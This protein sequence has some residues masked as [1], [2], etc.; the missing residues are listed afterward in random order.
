MPK[1]KPR[2]IKVSGYLVLSPTDEAYDAPITEI[3]VD[4]NLEMWGLTDLTEVVITDLPN[5]TVTRQGVRVGK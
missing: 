2:V 1:R 3:I 5:A 4:A